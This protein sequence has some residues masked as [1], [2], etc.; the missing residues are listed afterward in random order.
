MDPNVEIGDEALKNILYEQMKQSKVFDSEVKHYLRTPA[1][2]NYQFLM[3]ALDRFLALDRMERNRT[4][5]LVE[6]ERD[7]APKK[8]AAANVA[9]GDDKGSGGNP[10]AASSPPP[11]RRK[12]ACIDVQTGECPNGR[13][14]KYEHVKISQSDLEELKL[15]RQAALRAY[16]EKGKAKSKGNGKRS[17][18]PKQREQRLM[19]HSP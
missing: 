2:R 11:Q 1:D 15:R 16:Q 9:R 8:P 19:Q 12:L 3:R 6:Q 17:K 14:C 10:P 18:D 7:R 5:Q 13:E 4:T